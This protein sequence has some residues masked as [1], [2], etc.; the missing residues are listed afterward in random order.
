MNLGKR[1]RRDRSPRG[2]GEGKDEGKGSL[3]RKVA[4]DAIHS[5]EGSALGTMVNIADEISIV[6]HFNF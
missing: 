2:V 5:G 6:I 1:H 4:V 3:K